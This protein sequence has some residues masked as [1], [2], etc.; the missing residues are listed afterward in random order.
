MNLLL[1]TADQWRGDTLGHLGHACVRTPHLDALAAEGTSFARHYSVTA[2][3]GPARASLLTGLYAHNHRSILNGTPLDGRLTNL[4]LELRKAGYAPTLFGYTDTSAD[5][6]GLASSDPRLFSYEGVLPGFDVGQLLLEDFRPWLAWL[7]RRRGAALETHPP[8]HEPVD[9]R[10]G[11]AARYTAAES[12]TQFLA[13][14]AIDWLSTR[15]GERWCAHVSFLRPHPPWNAPAEY[16]AL[17]ADAEIPPPRRA[18]TAEADAAVHPLQAAVQA[19]TLIR[20]FVPGFEG[21]MSALDAV[22]VRDLRRAYYALMTEIDH[23]VGRLLDFLRDSGQLDDTLVVFT[24]D[25]GE[26]LG[27]HHLFGK[28]GYAEPAFHIPLIVRQPGGRRGARVDAFTESVDVMPTI[29]AALGI[30]VPAACDGRALTP[31]LAGSG[32]ADWRRAA[33]WEVDYRDLLG[34]SAPALGSDPEAASLVVHRA[35]DH[36]YVHF[37]AAPPLL[38]DLREDPA[39]TRNRADDP[40]AA[41]TRASCMS[42]LLSWRLRHE[43]RR[44]S[45]LRVTSQGLIRWR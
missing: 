2:P 35:D 43:D 14:A 18:A 29:L 26:C 25:H 24:S 8:I 32:P 19:Q 28:R 4:A 15:R 16:L 17:Y 21:R 36:A 30:E 39:W 33:H 42:D 10:L 7:A 40:G 12:E 3:C 27:D 6:A 37:A 38:F 23:H 13:D 31:F 1:I 45:N 5:P 41:A 9:G 34:P 22:S 44:M 20:S 11:G